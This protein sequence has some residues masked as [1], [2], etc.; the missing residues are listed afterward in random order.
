MQG[1]PVAR[2]ADLRE[3]KGKIIRLKVP[4]KSKR[5]TIVNFER[6]FVAY[7]KVLHE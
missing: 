5:R 6:Q 1:R 4:F 2:Q 3:G 7:W